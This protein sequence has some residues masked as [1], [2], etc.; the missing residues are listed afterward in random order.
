MADMDLGQALS[1]FKEGAQQ[2]SLSRALSQANDQVQQIKSSELNDQQQ[3]QQLQQLS[4]SLVTHMAGMGIPATTI[5]AVAGAVGPK[6]FANSNQMYMEGALTGNQQLMNEAGDVQKHEQNPESA[7]AKI[8]A[9]AAANDPYRQAMADEKKNQFTTKQFSKFSTDLDSQAASSRSAFGQWSQV[10]GRGDRLKSILGDPSSWSSMTPEQLELVKEGVVQMSKGGTMTESD[11]KALS[12]WM[13]KISAA[14][15]QT[16]LTGKPVSLDLSG[17][18]NLYSGLI[19]KESDAA[20]SNIQKTILT[21]A[22]GNMK[23]YERDPDQFKATIADR[24]N[25]QA[26]LNVNPDDILVD[27][28]KGVSVDPTALSRS[29]SSDSGSFNSNPGLTPVTVRDKNTGGFIK[30]FKDAMGNLFS[31]D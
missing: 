28:K 18:A 12:P 19:K 30:A 23:L 10:E 21:R 15:A 29:K 3:R 31:A 25:K 5:Q 20:T 16:A 7:I 11:H 4:N 1:M 26:G 22:T 13:A 9:K 8:Q 2:L 14:R 24:L 6:Q 27:K 17:F